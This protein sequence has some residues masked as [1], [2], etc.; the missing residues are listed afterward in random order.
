MRGILQGIALF[1]AWTVASLALGAALGRYL[2]RLDA[3]E[4]DRRR[5]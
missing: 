4:R 3:T 5:R 2:A 1:G